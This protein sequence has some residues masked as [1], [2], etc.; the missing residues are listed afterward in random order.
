[1]DQVGLKSW[2]CFRLNSLNM[3]WDNRLEGDLIEYHRF[4]CCPIEIPQAIINPIWLHTMYETATK[5]R[6]GCCSNNINF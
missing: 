3:G 2:I 4:L 5:L 6:K 1:M